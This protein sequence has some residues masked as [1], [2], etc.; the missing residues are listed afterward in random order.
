MSGVI[1]TQPK[2]YSDLVKAEFW[3]DQGWCLEGGTVNVSTATDLVIGSVMGKVTL[4]GKYVPRDPDATDGS[5]IAAAIIAKNVAVPASTDTT[6]QLIV[7]GP[8]KVAEESL[9]FDVEHDSTET[10]KAIS[11]L[12][13]LQIKTAPQLY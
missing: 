2:L 3:S 11:E 10:A 1:Y 12:A 13:A 4:T 6:V 9:I 5:E 8:M 7:N